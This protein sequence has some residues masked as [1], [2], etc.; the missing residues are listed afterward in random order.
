MKRN[1]IATSLALCAAA[2][3]WAGDGGDYDTASAAYKA[4]MKRNELSP[5]NV[6]YIGDR[7]KSQAKRI[8]HQASESADDLS[9]AAVTAALADGRRSVN[10]ASPQIYGTVRGSVYVISQRGRGRVT[11]VQ[12]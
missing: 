9:D 2:P 4:E 5:F 3:S 1:L 10:V 12:R 8:G 11:S 7:A 6:G